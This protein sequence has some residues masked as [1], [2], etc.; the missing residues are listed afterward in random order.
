MVL[1]STKDVLFNKEVILEE[2]ELLL[3]HMLLG[4]PQSAQYTILQGK[5]PLLR[6]DVDLLKRI[7]LNKVSG[8]SLAYIR[9][10]IPLFLLAIVDY[11]NKGLPI[12]T[13]AIQFQT[14]ISA[15]DEE[16]GSLDLD[17]SRALYHVINE[18]LN[19]PYYTGYL[20]SA[21]DPF[22]PFFEGQPQNSFSDTI[23]EVSELIND[24]S[25][26]LS[27]VEEPL[28]EEPER[29]FRLIEDKP[30][31]T[32]TVVEGPPRKVDILY[33]SDKGPPSGDSGL[34]HLNSNEAVPDYAYAVI[35]LAV[36]FAFSYFF[37]QLLKQDS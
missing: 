14:L 25:K 22:S 3:R 28:K 5:P 11:S 1:K 7:L 20:N 21:L 26:R 12:E 23:R 13:R 19:N 37:V 10:R 29:V 16:K 15:L 35:G 24:K 31:P 8:K 2:L 34:A 27:V 33:P 6:S 9:A 32:L 36:G 17:E 4:N 18:G 30:H